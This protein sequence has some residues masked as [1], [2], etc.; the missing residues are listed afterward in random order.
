[1]IAVGSPFNR[2]LKQTVTAGIVSAKGRTSVGLV[3]FENFIQT[4]AAINPGNSGGA[5]MNMR[6][7]LVGINTA[8]ATRSRGSQGVG[9][10]I[11]INMARSV[12]DDLLNEGRV[13]R[14]WLGVVIQSIDEDLA[15]S[16][17]L[18]SKSGVLINDLTA[19]APAD[20]AGI[21]RGDVVVEFEGKPVK[22]ADHL[23]NLVAARNPG[24]TVELVVV[25]DGKRKRFEVKLGERP[26]NPRQLL[27]GGD[28]SRGG[29]ADLTGRLGLEVE[30][31]TERLA[32]ELN[33]DDDASG[34]VVTEVRRGSPAATKNIRQGD[35]IVEVNQEA[36]TS[37]GDLTAALRDVKE[38]EPVLLLLRRGQTTF[39]TAVKMP[40]TRD[41]E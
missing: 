25:R 24:E 32:R 37:V 1:V 38:G 14:G 10:A 18:D 34:V 5:L 2:N 29:A 9:F 8:I 7:E 31:L 28:G 23:Q 40:E 20:R 21:Q 15:E 35:L 19:D 12:M 16:F 39:Y 4:D 33:L 30:P 3:D 6:G 26:A 22:D 13:V 11:P 41:D 27:A 36:V 17:D